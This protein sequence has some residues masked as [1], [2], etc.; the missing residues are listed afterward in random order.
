MSIHWGSFL[1]FCRL[2]FYILPSNLIDPPNF[3]DATRSEVDS[4]VHWAV[5]LI[6]I[7]S[8]IYIDKLAFTFQT[9]FQLKCPSLTV[10]YIRP[11]L[12]YF[13]FGLCLKI[14]WFF[15]SLPLSCILFEC[16]NVGH[17]LHRFKLILRF[18]QWRNDIFILKYSWFTMFW[19]TE[20]WFIYVYI[21]MCMCVAVCIYMHIYYF[22]HPFP[23]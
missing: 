14:N 23:L 11:L 13:L 21:Y 18:K 2:L 10:I 7:K 15:F 8:A 17:W 22:S 20:N 5:I 6:Q 16:G 3:S 12:T 19:Y 9:H 4:D 1:T